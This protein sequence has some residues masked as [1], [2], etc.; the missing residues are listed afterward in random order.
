[1]KLFNTVLITVCASLITF[2]CQNKKEPS[3]KLEK[4]NLLKTQL[5]EIENEITT[6]ETELQMSGE[7]EVLAVNEI[8]VT[9]LKV[10]EE[11]FQHKTDLR[12][13]VASRSN[14]L[15]T[16]ELMGRIAT[17][18]VSEGQRVA[19]GELL[20]TLNA[21]VLKDNIAE[22]KTQLDLAQI[23][24][25]KQTNL[26]EQNIGTEIQYL[27]VKSN[28]ESLERRLKTMQSQLNMSRI[29]APFEG[30]IDQV[31][32]KV[33]EFS[34]PGM[35]LLRLVNPASMYLQAAAS[36]VFLGKFEVGDSVQITFPIQNKQLY[37]IVTAVGQVID[38]QN[39]TFQLEVQLP[40]V[41][42]FVKPNQVV[43][44][45]LVDYENTHALTVPSKLI[46]TDNR[47]TFIYVIE[48]ESGK[49]IAKKAHIETGISFKNKTEIVS[50]LARGQWVAD[51]GYRELSEDVVVELINKN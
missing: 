4:L 8:K 5:K 9:A 41:D 23:I 39:R 34:Q 33:G 42:F 37:S 43:V 47:G 48:G 28:A 51:K 13:G 38:G 31:I 10:E 16:S 3:D 25:E 30:V 11:I 14:V 40:K 6:I 21:Q 24:F 49:R 22:V 2:S 29:Y 44:L 50:G 46:Q 1:M 7:L 32:A 17:I 35:P 27:Q 18:N 15:L 36:E 19:G 45:Q 26:W 20:I 12:A